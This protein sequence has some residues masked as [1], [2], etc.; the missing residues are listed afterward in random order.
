[1]WQHWSVPLP[2]G[3]G[4]LSPAW[5]G[6]Q[7]LLSVPTQLSAFDSYIQIAPRKLNSGP[8]LGLIAPLR[9]LVRSGSCQRGVR[10]SP[11][12]GLWPPWPC[13][14]SKL[15]IPLAVP[16]HG[17]QGLAHTDSDLSS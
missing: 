5:K 4:K 14:A 6:H 1:M 13:Q 16:L 10:D 17:V 8:D 15:C 7:Y 12:W 11:P 9:A 3:T 2:V